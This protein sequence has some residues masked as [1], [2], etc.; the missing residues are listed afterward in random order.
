MAIKEKKMIR[1]RGTKEVGIEA[2]EDEEAKEDMALK[3][4]KVIELM[5]WVDCCKDFSLLN[6]PFFLVSCLISV[7]CDSLVFFFE[8]N[9]TSYL[10]KLPKFGMSM[11]F[12]FAHTMQ[13]LW[14]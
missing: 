2:E 10:D 4:V 8:F 11:E 7:F 5:L 9:N 3:E 1:D 6:N 14:Q 13:P 12:C